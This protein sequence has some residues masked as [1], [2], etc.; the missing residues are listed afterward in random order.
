M[1]AF[2]LYAFIDYVDIWSVRGGLKG[3]K[4]IKTHPA[5]HFAINYA[6]N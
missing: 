3:A 6:L 4:G 5:K 1:I 2:C